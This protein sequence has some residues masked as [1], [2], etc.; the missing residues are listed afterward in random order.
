MICKD[1][2]NGFFLFV[3]VVVYAEVE[4]IRISTAADLSG[5]LG[6]TPDFPL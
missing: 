4:E 2:A 3:R 6:S 1:P 5:P